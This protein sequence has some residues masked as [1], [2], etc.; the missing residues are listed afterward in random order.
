MDFIVI[1]PGY[2]ANIHPKLKCTEE[3]DCKVFFDRT[4]KMFWVDFD[5]T[6]QNGK[7]IYK[8]SLLTSDVYFIERTINDFI[9]AH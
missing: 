1:Y 8:K 6:K 2:R 3:L 9:S 7:V 4:S 5:I